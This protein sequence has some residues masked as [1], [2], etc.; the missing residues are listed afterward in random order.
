MFHVPEDCRLRTHRQLGTD[1]SYGNNGVFILHYRKEELHVIAS[2]DRDWPPEL[3]P[4]KWEHVSVTA[5]NRIP[6]WEEMCFVKNLFWDLD[7]CV[8]QFHPPGWRY[9]NR[10]PNCLHLW[11]PIEFAIPL[12][13]IQCI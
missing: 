7:D 12:P 13:P 2:D 5:R 3:G 11:R 6:T 9:V 1:S 10:N 4:L 8:I